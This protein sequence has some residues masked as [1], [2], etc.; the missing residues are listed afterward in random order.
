MEQATHLPPTACQEQEAR[1]E[2]WEKEPVRPGKRNKE[3]GFRGEEAAARFLMR[4]GYVIL[5]RNWTCF[6]GEADIIALDEDVL[7]FIEV[8]TRRGIEKGFPSEAV[9]KAKRERY[10]KIALAYVQE[11]FLCDATLRFDVIS[12]V[13][14]CDDRAC[15]KHHVGAFSRGEQ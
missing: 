5:E 8:K 9:G 1:A 7:V 13:A 2:H 10:E 14:L 3:L 11:H 4:R 6:A 12:I 15:V